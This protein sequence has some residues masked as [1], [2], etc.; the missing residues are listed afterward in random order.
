M[1]ADALGIDEARLVSARVSL[2]AADDAERKRLRGSSSALSHFSDSVRGVSQSTAG[3]ENRLS[4]VW[5]PG[6]AFVLLVADSLSHAVRARVAARTARLFGAVFVSDEHGEGAA[7][8]DHLS[9]NRD[10]SFLSPP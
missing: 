2:V 5:Q 9:R 1:D 7:V 8:R 10:S 3:C 4:S 6:R